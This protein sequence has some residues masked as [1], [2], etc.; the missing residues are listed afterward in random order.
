V[1]TP[2]VETPA[3]RHVVALPPALLVTGVTLAVALALELAV[4]GPGGRPALGDIPGR[5]LAWRL[6]PS[7]VP[8]GGGPVEYP[9]VIG[10]VAWITVWFG[11]RAT[12]FF[13]VN[14]AVAAALALGVTALIRQRSGPRIWRWAAG[15][16]LALYAFHNWDLVAIAPALLGLYAFERAHDRSAGALIAIGASAK[17][18]PALLLPPLV[19][20]RWQ[21]GDRRGAVRL[22][23]AFILVT[24]L[25]NGPIALRS[26]HAWT[27]PMSFQG[28]RAPTWASTW[29]WLFRA[30]ALR[31]LLAHHLTTAADLAF[32]V[33][34][35][36]ALVVISARAVRHHLGAMEIAAAVFG[37]FLLANKVYSPNY[38]LWLVPFF[39]LLPISRRVW[40]GYCASDL[41]IF[42]LVY[43]HFHGQW[44]SST[45]LAVLPFLVVLRSVA[46]VAMVLTALRVGTRGVADVAGDP[47]LPPGPGPTVRIGGPGSAIAPDR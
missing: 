2:S 38:D 47:R 13:L 22:S 34:L 29:Y 37:V 4:L 35:A 41:A 32:V 7:L 39:A 20:V 9:V 40:I 43:G 5:F 18:F 28:G 11:R 17:V 46:I 23:G 33:A 42:V 30:P 45:V 16:P 3:P 1:T 44:P 14:S 10:Y 15:V 36:A 24:L 12:E 26:W 6:H 27:Y 31:G 21:A 8:Y 19:V 25:L